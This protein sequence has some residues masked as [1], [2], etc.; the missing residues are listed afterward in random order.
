MQHNRQSEAYA[1]SVFEKLYPE[2]PARDEILRLLATSIK[3]AHEAGPKCWEVTLGPAWF[4]F[5]VGAG[6]SMLGHLGDVQLNLDGRSLD[7][8]VQSG[9]RH[10][11]TLREDPGL[12]SMTQPMTVTFSDM[13]ICEA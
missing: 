6:W 13:E 10:V 1:G 4:T 8:E 11:A 9:I 3:F 2:K 7:M 5:N 12:R